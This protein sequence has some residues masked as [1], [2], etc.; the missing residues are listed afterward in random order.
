[1]SSLHNFGVDASNLTRTA[2]NT[3]RAVFGLIG[4][5]ALVIGLLMTFQPVKTVGVIVILL[6]IYF[7]IAGVAYVVKAIFSS[8]AKVGARVLDAV[9]GI[10]MIV[11]AI[12]VFND[13]AATAVVFGIF[14]G[15]FVGIAWI[16]EGIGSLAQLGDVTSKVWTTLFAIISIIAGFSLLFSPLWGAATL[17]WISGI[18]LIV[19]G[20]VQ[21][22][23]AFAFGRDA[24]KALKNS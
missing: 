15:V 23:R 7:L 20:V 11:A 4:L 12:I 14:L 22:I 8:G 13:R 2:I 6:G 3:T 21:I 10:I 5:A 19:I 24:L 1:M 9:L 17:F 16:L 18:A